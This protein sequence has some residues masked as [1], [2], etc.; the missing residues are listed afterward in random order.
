MTPKGEV[1]LGPGCALMLLFF[2]LVGF[3]YCVALVWRALLLLA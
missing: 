3:A 2:T 1:Q